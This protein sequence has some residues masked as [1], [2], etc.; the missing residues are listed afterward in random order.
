MNNKMGQMSDYVTDD[1]ATHMDVLPDI[2]VPALE[3]PRKSQDNTVNSNYQLPLEFLKQSELRIA[4]GRVCED[5][6]VG[7]YTFVG[8][9]GSSLVDYCIANYFNYLLHF[10]FTTLIHS[11]ITVLLNFR[12][13][14]ILPLAHLSKVIMLIIISSFS[15]GVVSLRNTRPTYPL[16][17]LKRNLWH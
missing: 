3:L 4:N 6:E 8:S 1:F 16:V 2:Y 12:C 9:R 15:N 11:L 7:T 10:M 5:Q 14:Q 13:R 17:H